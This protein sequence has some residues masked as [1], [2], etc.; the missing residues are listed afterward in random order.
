M[1]PFVRGF[2]R[3]SLIW[4]AVGVTIGVSMAF[5]P[6]G[7]LVYRTAHIHA[8]LLGFVSMMIFGV[9]YHVMPRFTGNPLHSR[10]EAAVHLWLA[11]LGLVLLVGGWITRVWT[12]PAGDVALRAGAAV[13]ALGILLFIHNLWRTLGPSV[14]GTGRRAPVPAVAQPPAVH[15]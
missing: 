1:E 3:A 12:W 7:A 14:A 10:R 4:L 5:W 13:S 2:I 8:N 6:Q 15:S 11:N 9:A